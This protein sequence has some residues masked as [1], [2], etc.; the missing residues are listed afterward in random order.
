MGKHGSTLAD[1]ARVAG[2]SR[3]TAS[4]AYNR[5]D[6][7]SAAVRTRVLEAAA[8]LGYAG[9]DPLARQL[10]TRRSGTVG[11]LVLERPGYAFS[12]PAAQLFLDGIAEGLGADTAGLLLLWGTAENG[13]PPVA[14]VR[15]AAVDGFVSYC[16]PGDTP[17]LDVVVQRGVPLVTVD[18]TVNRGEACVEVANHSGQAAV[19]RHLLGLGHRRL[20]VVSMPLRADGFFG[21]ADRARLTTVTDPS[22]RDRLAA[23]RDEVARAGLDPDAV[24]VA[25]ARSSHPTDGHELA[26]MLLARHPRPTAIIALSDRLALGCIQA[27][28]AAGLRVPED[29][30][31]TGFDAIPEAYEAEPPLTTVAQDHG[32]K[33]RQ[34]GQLIREM[35]DGLPARHAQVRTELVVGGSTGPPPPAT[36]T[37]SAAG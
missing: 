7:L 8:S 20:A 34:A 32:L 15:A 29:V 4:N 10:R 9:P 16:L 31:V 22:S 24:P 13:G 11:V 18:G 28:R 23:V 35:L 21:L 36:A 3:S 26:A 27:V 14:A 37:G 33:G 19:V 6:Q 30:S 25:V 5:P 2:V 12:D 17:A 1:V